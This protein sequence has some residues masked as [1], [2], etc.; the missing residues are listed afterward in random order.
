MKVHQVIM[1]DNVG[2]VINECRYK[3]GVLYRQNRSYDVE[4]SLDDFRSRLNI[5]KFS[6]SKDKF[7]NTLE[8]NIL[9]VEPERW[10]QQGEKA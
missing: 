4:V 1:R 7:G 3:N 10:L 5:S 2:Q 9:D 8:Y 6:I